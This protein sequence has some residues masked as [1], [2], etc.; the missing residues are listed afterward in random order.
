MRKYETEIL[1]FLNETGSTWCPLSVLSTFNVEDALRSQAIYCRDVKG[2][3]FVTL[4]YFYW[5][6]KRIA[7]K[8]V[9]RIKPLPVERQLVSELISKFEAMESQRMGFKFQFAEEQKEGIFTFIG[10]NL[11]ILTGGPGTGKTS[12]LKCAATIIKWINGKTSI[13]FTAP[14]GKA[15]RRVTES[16]GFPA[17]TLQRDIGDSG[18]GNP[19]KFVFVDNYFTDECSMLDMD[20]F[21]KTL[22]SLGP[23]TH[24]YLVG[25]VNQL[26]SVGIGAVL[27]DLIDSK[28]IPCCQLEKTFR[29]DNSSVL[30]DNIQI[31]NSGGYIPLQ[32]GPDFVRI[33]TEENVMQTCIE[34]YI[35]GVKEFGLDQTVILTPYRKEGTICSE[36]LN[37]ILQKKL[38]PIGSAPF[39]KTTV[40]HDEGR[41]LPIIFQT[42][43]PVMQLFNRDYIAN[44]D[45]GKIINVKPEKGIVV[46]KYCDCTIEY[47]KD[48]LDQLDLAYSLSIHKSQGSEYKNVIIPILR[49]NKNVDRNSIYTGITRAKKVC[50]LIGEDQVIMDACKIQS[51]WQR[52]T[53]LADEIEQAFYEK[54]LVEQIMVS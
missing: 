16:S 3:V 39:I 7:R 45:V 29:Q 22:D 43:D 36:K 8:V 33:K 18:C 41:A 42:G 19:L 1:R 31:V 37:N 30:F 4:P 5:Q 13:T 20:T 49:E 21:E 54:K 9:A 52:Y 50:C 44:G 51:A 6:E 38:N 15:A 11:A 34:R 48:E 10:N 14:T 46:V 17:T 47:Q 23:N 28:A 25:D 24:F 12:V 27:R 53:A 26:P 32:E 2:T 40:Y 35:S